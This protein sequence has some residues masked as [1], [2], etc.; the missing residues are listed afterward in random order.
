M[1]SEWYFFG[2]S[3]YPA[4]ATSV[5]SAPPQHQIRVAPLNPVSDLVPLNPA[6]SK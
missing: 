1:R 6:A 4:P 5:M 2:R 3:L